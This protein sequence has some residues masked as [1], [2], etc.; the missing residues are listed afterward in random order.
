MPAS[1]GGMRLH[2]IRGGRSCLLAAL[3]LSPAAAIAAESAGIRATTGAVMVAQAAPASV[4][5]YQYL[6][7]QYLAARQR[8]G[9]GRRL[10]E[11]RGRQAA[12]ARRQAP[13]RSGRPACGLRADPAAALCGAVAP[14]RSFGAERGAAA[15]I[16]AGRRRLPARGGAG[17]QVRAAAAAARSST[18][19]PT[20]RSRPRP[21]SRASRRSASTRSS[22]AATAST[23][24]RRKLEYPRPDARAFQRARLQPALVHQQR[25]AAGGEGHQFIAAL[26]GRP[27]DCP[28][29]RRR[30][31]SA[32]S[33][34]SRA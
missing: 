5:Q 23:T 28:A 26:Q 34:C 1:L 11:R 31:C 16:R 22:P 21:G 4:A 24:C 7:A 6:L 30:R 20:P 10:L 15:K 12:T 25:R 2:S 14:D 33:P 3:L 9:R 17:I 29:I 8:R 19:A 32:R 27:R 18:S 13:Q